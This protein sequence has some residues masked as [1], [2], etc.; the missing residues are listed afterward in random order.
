MPQI[1]VVGMKRC[2]PKYHNSAR[3]YMKWFHGKWISVLHYAVQLLQNNYMAHHVT[4]TGEVKNY[5]L[6]AK[7]LCNPF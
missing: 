2:L 3:S 1:C 4:H 7:L 6:F 5:M